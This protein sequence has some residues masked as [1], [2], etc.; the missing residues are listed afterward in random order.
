MSIPIGKKGFIVNEEVPEPYIIV[1]DELNNTGGYLVLVSAT[2]DFVNGYDYWVL[3]GDL[4]KFFEEA[5]WEV[6]WSK[7]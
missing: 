1:Q 6:T 3:Q 2:G 4:E 7:D 5:K